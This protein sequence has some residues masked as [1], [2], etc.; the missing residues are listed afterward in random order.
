MMNKYRSK[1]GLELV[2]FFAL[3]TGWIISSDDDPAIWLFIIPFLGFIA[4]V[5]FS[6]R[7]TTDEKNLVISHS[8]F[9]K[10]KIPVKS[11]RRITETNNLL[12]SPAA[13]L[14][15]LEILYNGADVILISPVRTEEFLQ[16]LLKV[17]PDIEIIKK[18]HPNIFSRLAV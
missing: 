14:D 16:D 15:R 5:L 4:A 8:F 12:S 3:I 18:D 11:V 2:G 17:N 13:S 6:I 7:Y 9:I 10:N 1:I